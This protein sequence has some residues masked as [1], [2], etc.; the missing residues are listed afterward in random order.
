MRKESSST[1]DISQKRKETLAVAKANSIVLKKPS[2]HLTEGLCTDP[3]D[4]VSTK[5]ME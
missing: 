4:I 1:R 3:H 2:L 5:A